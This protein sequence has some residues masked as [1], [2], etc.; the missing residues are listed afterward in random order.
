MLAAP[1]NNISRCYSYFKGWSARNGSF[2]Q[3]R[4]SQIRRQC[5]RK[6]YPSSSEKLP[7]CAPCHS[8]LLVELSASWLTVGCSLIVG[9]TSHCVRQEPNILSHGRQALSRLPRICRPPQLKRER[10]VLCKQRP[11]ASPIPKHFDDPLARQ[12]VAVRVYRS[13]HL[14]VGLLVFEQLLDMLDNDVRIRTDDT[15]KSGFCGLGPLR[16]L[17]QDKDR[18]A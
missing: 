1:R 3:L 7:P 13:R 18:H 9:R 12:S 6:C 17:A 2:G 15:G 5:G 10:T 14:A 8:L 11:P 4:A 16:R